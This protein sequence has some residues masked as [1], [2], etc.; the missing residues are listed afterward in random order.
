MRNYLLFRTKCAYW[1][2]LFLNRGGVLV[3]HP[4]TWRISLFAAS[5][6]ISPLANSLSAHP[7]RSS[8]AY[9]IPPTMYRFTQ[10]KQMIVT[11]S[12]IM[13]VCSYPEKSLA[14]ALAHVVD[15]ASSTAV[16]THERARYICLQN[17]LANLDLSQWID[18]SAV[19]FSLFASIV[20]VASASLM[21]STSPQIGPPPLKGCF[22]YHPGI[23]FPDS[24]SLCPLKLLKKDKSQ[25]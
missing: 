12:E 16:A 6:I 7:S 4:W 23:E 19:C 9:R 25:L 15:H 11:M 17:F 13:I 20:T 2:R 10:A 8:A 22:G 5:G 1:L 18:R 24:G 14:W 3:L 21:L